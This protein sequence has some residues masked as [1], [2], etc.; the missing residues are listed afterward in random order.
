ML[1]LQRA[2]RENKTPLQLVQT[3]VVAIERQKRSISQR[4]Q[5]AAR[6]LLP[7]QSNAA[8]G[9]NQP[10]TSAGIPIETT[11]ASP[12]NSDLEGGSSYQ[13]G[14]EFDPGASGG[15]FT[16]HYSRRPFFTWF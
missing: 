15:H 7:P 9:R 14:D 4:I 10:T 3:P 1:N 12:L 8:G 16:T 11:P 13:S 2:L 5:Q 6:E